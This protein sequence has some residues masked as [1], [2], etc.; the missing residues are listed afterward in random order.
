MFGISHFIANCCHVKVS[1]SASFI[2]TNVH[3]SGNCLGE[4]EE[5]GLSITIYQNGLGQ[6]VKTMETKQFVSLLD[7]GTVL[8]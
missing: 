3:R 6:C 8:K 7:Y 4:A 2:E 5:I 1:I